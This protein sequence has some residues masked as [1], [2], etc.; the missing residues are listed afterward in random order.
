MTTTFATLSGPT[1]FPAQVKLARRAVRSEPLSGQIVRRQVQSSYARSSTQQEIR[2]WG[3]TFGPL[4]T[5]E[6]D[7][8]LATF[9]AAQG[10]ARSILWTPTSEGSPIAVRIVQDTLR[11]RW[12]SATWWEAT[13]ELEEVA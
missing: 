4:T 10:R 3:V 1:A 9:D 13:L 6:R 7:S 8:V 11:L 12:L 2:R 5:A